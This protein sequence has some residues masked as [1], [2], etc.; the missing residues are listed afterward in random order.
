MNASGLQQDSMHL[1]RTLNAHL[2]K[3]R[4]S[5]RQPWERCLPGGPRTS[6]D[7]LGRIDSALPVKT[8]QEMKFEQW[9]TC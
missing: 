8:L 7:H 5:Q 3:A 4:L 6:P 1:Q 9:T 2:T